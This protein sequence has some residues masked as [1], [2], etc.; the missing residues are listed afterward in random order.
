MLFRSDADRQSWLPGRV[1]TWRSLEDTTKPE[2]IPSDGFP[3]YFYSQT[4]ND[5]GAGVIRP[6]GL[7]EVDGDDPCALEVEVID[8]LEPLVSGVEFKLSNGDSYSWRSVA[9]A[10]EFGDGKVITCKALEAVDPSTRAPEVTP[11]A[12][13]PPAAASTTTDRPHVTAPT[14]AA[15]Q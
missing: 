5:S 6:L 11:P 15:H 3:S 7:A 2:D 4:L 14:Q 12:S 1:Y 10:D 13:A 9:G 8:G